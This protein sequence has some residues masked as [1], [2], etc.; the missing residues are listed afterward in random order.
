MEIMGNYCE[1]RIICLSG[2]EIIVF[3]ITYPSLLTTYFVASILSKRGNKKTQI[4]NV[5]QSRGAVVYVINSVSY[6]R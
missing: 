2:I 3:E 5:E 6:F 1:I 4:G